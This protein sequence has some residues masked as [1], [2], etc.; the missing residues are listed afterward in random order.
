MRNLFSL[1]ICML[2]FLTS[3]L[4]AGEVKNTSASP[5]PVKCYEGSWCSK[6]REGFGLTAGQAIELCSGTANANKTLLCFSKA[7]GHTNDGG[8]G[9][10]LGQ[11]I[12]LCKSNQ[13]STN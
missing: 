13:S 4:E 5:E 9:L 8:L 12:D 3:T 7:W 1:M 10:T 6:D 11:A 2:F